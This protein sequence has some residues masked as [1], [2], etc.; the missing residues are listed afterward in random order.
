MKL[1]S[2]LKVK[3]IAELIGGKII[4]KTDLLITK[5][6]GIEDSEPG[7][8]SF[9]YHSKYARYLESCKATCVI[10]PENIDIAPKENQTFIA[11]KN[12]YYEFCR[13]L[14]YVESLQPKKSS[15]IHKTAIIGENAG[16]HESAYIGPYCV[17]GDNCT[18][19]ENVVLHSNVVLYDEVS[20]DSG[21]ELH[22]SAVCYSGT[23][24]GKNCL[25]QA[26]AVIGSDGFGFIEN[27]D[28]S[29]EKIPQLGNVVIEDDVEIGANT[30][31]DCALIGSTVIEKGCKID[32]LVQIAHNVR[33]GENTG[34]AAQAGISGSSKI[35]K[36]NRLA[37][38][39]GIAG[40]IST[41]DDVVL[42]AQSGIGK[43][44]EAKGIYFG[45]PA[46]ERLKAFKIEAI[47][48]NLP[49]LYKE[50]LELRKK[51]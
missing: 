29:Y 5:I 4:G 10:V 20:I 30:T 37:G 28:S 35:G 51:I 19:A 23:V 34:I 26:G 33:I 32:N 8:I 47:I 44:I 9:Y 24:I 49:D 45:S 21:S 6:S 2:P 11:I 1:K 15:F 16:I 39:S 42:Y 18:I 27:A 36:R 43:S 14:K 17:I 48:N 46:R 7:D 13:V 38:Q 25:V 41:A 22:S 50:F 31:I 12:P 3:T 40:H